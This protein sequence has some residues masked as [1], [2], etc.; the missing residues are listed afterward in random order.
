MGYLKNA[1][2]IMLSLPQSNVNPLQLLIKTSSGTVDRLNASIEDLFIPQ[3]SAP[4]D[5][6]DDKPLPEIQG[7]EELN[8][9]IS[10][11]VG[12]LKGLTN[13]FNLKGSA[14]FS[15]EQGRVFKIKLNNPQQNAVNVIKLAGFIK[16]AKVNDNVGNIADNLEGN[17]IYVITEVIKAKSFRIERGDNEHTKGEVVVN[18]PGIVQ[19]SASTDV[20]RKD[21]SDL[22]YEGDTPLTFALKAFRIIASGGGWFSGNVKYS[23]ESAKD[24]ERVREG[25][26][27]GEHLAA[28][29]SYLNIS[30]DE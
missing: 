1:G 7:E 21:S 6:G 10:A 2:F 5:V 25:S 23:I 28:P 14:N 12:F 20:G 3:I 9:R 11:D 27:Y 15:Y 13:F 29:E 4:P 19:G 22:S 24:V 26:F 16:D 30:S 8:M 17:E 18:A